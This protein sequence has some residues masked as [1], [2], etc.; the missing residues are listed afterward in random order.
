MRRAIASE[1]SGRGW[2]V[3]T[4]IRGEE[5]RGRG[6]F[7]NWIANMLGDE[8]LVPHV[9]VPENTSEEA[10]QEARTAFPEA[11]ICIHCK[12]GTYKTMHRPLDGSWHNLAIDDE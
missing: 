3:T 7:L 5:L 12:D 4:E 8:G 10:V 9:V 6:D 11:S 1:A 2:E